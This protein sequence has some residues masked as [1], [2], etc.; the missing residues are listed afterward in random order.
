MRSRAL[1]RSA[2]LKQLLIHLRDATESGDE[3]RL[4]ETAIGVNFFHRSG[5]SPKMDTIVRSE[6]VRLRRK[7]E[8]YYAAEGVADTVRLVIGKNVYRLQL[9][10][11]EPALTEVVPAPSQPRRVRGFW[12][13]AAVGLAAGVVLAAVLLLMVRSQVPF[14]AAEPAA[15]RHPLW[16]GFASTA[17]DVCY[18]S[19]LFFKY[20][21]GYERN[22]GLNRPEDVH[23]AMGLL[24]NWPAIPV[25]DKWAPFDDV[26][27]AVTLDRFLRGLH[28][29][30]SVFS[31]RQ[32]SVGNLAG[33]RT[34]ILGHPRFAPL[35]QEVLSDL[36]FRG[37]DPND[38]KGVSGFINVHPQPG[39]RDRYYNRTPERPDDQRDSFLLNNVDESGADYGLITSVHLPGG[40]DVLSMFGD[41]TESSSEIARALT[42]S[43]FLDDLQTRVFHSASRPYRS[44]QI[45]VRIDYIRGKP[46]GVVY[47]THRIRF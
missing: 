20:S 32:Q 37:P 18:G 33:R 31:A 36:D 35:L 12:T 21:F 45:V 13:G 19:A 1:S 17:V 34:I 38:G 46:T 6:M 26:A 42:T 28:S 16:R 3:A 25:W 27:A 15:A 44:A 23:K 4:S 47:V 10:P 5:F 11:R 24:K 41:R 29:A 40:G 7:L 8:E 43:N 30:A 22:W 2:Q 9:M 14:L 39:E